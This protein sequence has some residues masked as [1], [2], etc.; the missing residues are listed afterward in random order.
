MSNQI[1]AEATRKNQLP[2]TQPVCNQFRK[3]TCRRSVC[4]YRHI[5]KEEEDAEILELIQNNSVN[6]QRLEQTHVNNLHESQITHLL[7]SNGNQINYDMVILILTLFVCQKFRFKPN[8]CG[9]F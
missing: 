3:G 2:G 8:R 1:L 4:K 7:P 6:K 9:A 5:T